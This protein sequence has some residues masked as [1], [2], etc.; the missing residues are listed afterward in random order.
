MPFSGQNPAVTPDQL[1]IQP[2]CPFQPEILLPTG[3]F[4]ARVGLFSRPN[5]ALACRDRLVIA[6]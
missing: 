4:P 5:P 3:R 6:E 1:I 2:D